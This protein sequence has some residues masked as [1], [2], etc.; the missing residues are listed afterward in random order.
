MPLCPSF[1]A[2]ASSAPP[3][4]AP[5]PSSLCFPEYPR[6][7]RSASQ[8]PLPLMLQSAQP[9]SALLFGK[10]Q[11]ETTSQKSSDPD[12]QGERRPLERTQE[13]F[14]VQMFHVKRSASSVLGKRPI[15]ALSSREM[16]RPARRKA[17]RLSSLSP[18]F[19][20]F[21]SLRIRTRLP[22]TEQDGVRSP[23]KVVGVL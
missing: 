22:S 21:A 6:G 23:K 9:A 2:P 11:R 20:E 1:P 18:L 7:V 16:P 15:Q 12:I 13:L 4:P 8:V 5:A 17:R 3:F 19:P 10:L 14:G